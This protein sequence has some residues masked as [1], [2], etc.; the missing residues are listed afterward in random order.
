MAQATAEKARPVLKEIDPPWGPQLAFLKSGAVFR[1]YQGGQGSGKT[2]AGCFEVRR[3]V[4]LHPGAIVICTEPTFP[5]VRDILQVEFDRQFEEAGELA[6]VKWRAS[7]HKYRCANGSEIWLRQSDKSDALRG[8]SV[9]AVWMDEAAQSPFAAYQIIVGRMRQ[10]GYPHRF[11][12]TGTPRG[13]NWLHWTFTPGD[14]PEEA[15]KFIGDAAGIGANSF[16][17]SALDN[18]YLDAVTRAALESAYPPGSLLHRQ[19]VLGESVLFEGLIYTG[20]DPETH[21]ADAP[22]GHQFVRHVIGCDWGWTNPGVLLVVGLDAADWTWSREEVV[23]MERPM[24]WWVAEARRLVDK[25][26]AEAILCDPS[27]P[28]NVTFFRRHNLPAKGANNSVIP[29]IT[30]VSARI[31][32]GRERVSPTCRNELREY[33]SYSWKQERDGAAKADEPLKVD[34]H[35]MDARRYAQM[36]LRRPRPTFR[37]YQG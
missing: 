30:A 37:S 26:H 18:P 3:Y 34:D 28:A 20:F 13:K 1:R 9:A 8:P 31:N 33:Q 27:E 24:E 2:V 4:K 35:V 23:A 6:W 36:G 7:E 21:V 16:F 12:A 29:G 17:S 14:R 10:R 5:M 19:E 22:A 15:P 25:Y 32:S 11:L